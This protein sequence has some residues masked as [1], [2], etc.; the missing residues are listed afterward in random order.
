MAAEILIA[1]GI[2]GVVALG[3]LLWPGP[4][5]PTPVASVAVVA[6]SLSR[7]AHWNNNSNLSEG[8]ALFAFTALVV[9]LGVSWP[10]STSGARHN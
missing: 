7:L 5:R 10:E 6:F 1:L 9:F 4:L 2:L 8:F 3:V